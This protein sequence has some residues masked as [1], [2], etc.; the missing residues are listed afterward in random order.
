LVAL[1]FQQFLRRRWIPRF[2]AV[3]SA[4][5]VVAILW[6]SA[7]VAGF[8]IRNDPTF[9][10]L[11]LPLVSI[12]VGSIVCLIVMEPGS[13][14]P[15]WVILR[16]WPMRTVGIVSYTLYLIHG[17]VY[18]LLSRVI[19]S[20]AVCALLSLGIALCA[21]W[22]SWHFIESPIL[23]MGEVPAGRLQPTGVPVNTPLQSA[24]PYSTNMQSP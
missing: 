5:L 18:L 10:I 2:L 24:T 20:P 14:H 4:G 22:L 7:P 16:S 15:A 13:R 23:A 1:L 9:M 6:R 21:A 8:E 12:F 17:L 19:Q 3:L 11:G